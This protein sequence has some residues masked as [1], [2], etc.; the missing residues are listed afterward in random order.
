MKREFI[1]HLRKTGEPQY[2]WT[3]LEE[4][5]K[6]AGQFADKIGLKECGELIG[7]LHDLGKASQ[8]FQNYILS[9]EGKIDPDADEYV[10]AK[11]Q[12]GKV[13][14]SSA[15]AQVIHKRLSTMGK[16][17]AIVGEFL[18]L[19]IASHH[20]GMIDCLAPDG[21]NNY[22]RR[23]RKPEE[24]TH[25][26]KAYSNLDD[27]ER[28]KVEKFFSDNLIEQL[29]AKLQ[30][31]KEENDSKQS[32]IFKFGLLARFLFSCLIDADR[33]STADFEFPRN[34]KIRNQGEYVAWEALIE[35]FNAKKFDNKNRV[36]VLRDAVSRECLEF[37]KR[38]KGLYQ[39]T[40]PT[41]GGKTFASLRFALNHAELHK[42]D[43]IIYIIPYTSIIDQ[44][45]DEVRK[46]LEEK[47]DN[48]KYLDRVVLEHHSNLTPD[49][50][51]RRQNLLSENWDAPIV[52]TTSVQFL[53]ALFASG[54]RSARR[55]HQLANAVIIFDEVQTLPVRFVHMFNVAIRF[56]VKGCGSTVLLCTAT[57]PL[58]DKIEIK[59]RALQ[60]SKDQQ[61]I[62]NV[63]SLFQ[64]LKRVEVYDQRKAAGWSESEIISLA[65]QETQK[66]GSVLIVV[67]TK[68]SAKN[69]YQQFKSAN[70]KDIFHLS[71][72]MC[73]EHRLN[74]LN[75]IK[76]RLKNNQ[77]TI[78]VSTQLIEAGVDIDFGSVIRYLA[79]LDSI[80]QSAGRCNRHGLRTKYGNVFIINPQDENLNRLEEIRIAAEDAQRVLGEFKESPERFKND[81]LSPA[82]MEQYY[83]YY[84]F[85]R[86]DKMN[87]PVPSK[88]P[89]GREDNLFDL[90]STNPKSV[91][92]NQ[93]THDTPLTISLWQSF[94][95]ASKAFR[96]IDSPTMGVIVPYGEE[97][98]QIIN[99]LC[100]TSEVDKEYKLLK[101][102]QRF[103]VNVY[104]NI[105][106]NLTKDGIIKEAQAG[107]GIFYLDYQYYS[108]EFG[109]S[110]QIVN[111]METYIVGR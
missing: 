57:Q 1:A 55:M 83:K 73:P 60:L 23:M 104:E 43:R 7:L 110:S 37:S 24:K 64:N 28:E 31:L 86:R 69:L 39:L 77:A 53:E 36:D 81:I 16:E 61:I 44:N 102:A 17:G 74:V 10:D 32:L 82:A 56:L 96:A 92:E 89:V 22:E 2:L 51:T 18:S 108:S 95:T 5:S 79:G 49:E 76:E 70:I 98:K 13:D 25:G 20:S 111:E 33:L 35:R 19:C 54:T 105:F 58:L 71:T 4:A 27:A 100:S 106:S 68:T 84:F 48:G 21:S 40:V 78:C 63:E 45:A 99:E 26:E 97:G 66:N 87:Y 41:G 67:N 46:I 15:G 50:E 80:A 85:D 103:S 65:Q 101:R 47:D 91:Q 11:A 94:Q 14:H 8:E 88:S 6:L 75:N 9:A 72:D 29:S 93:R 107:I 12:K 34:D 109:L 3:H 62:Q 52:F 90:L 59:E 30:S 42:M 38:P